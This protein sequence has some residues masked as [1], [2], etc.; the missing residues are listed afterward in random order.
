MFAHR[1]AAIS[2]RGGII[3]GWAV[4]L[5]M[6]MPGPLLGANF[7]RDCRICFREFLHQHRQPCEAFAYRLGCGTSRLKRDKISLQVDSR[8][9]LMS[10]SLA[11][12]FGTTMA[13]VSTDSSRHQSGCPRWVLEAV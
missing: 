2:T 10:G 4:S 5:L 13:E 9:A 8:L 11:L 7:L 1:N 12:T 6:V 3:Y